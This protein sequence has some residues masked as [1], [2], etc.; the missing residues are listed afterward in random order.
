M[1][2]LEEFSLKK[3]K[4]FFLGMKQRLGK[5]YACYVILPCSL[6]YTTTVS[7]GNA[8]GHREAQHQEE[9]WFFL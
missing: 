8:I 9:L 2:G 5:V 4:N 6:E 1:V 7:P 3:V